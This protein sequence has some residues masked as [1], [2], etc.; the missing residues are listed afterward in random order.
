M[1]NT[2]FLSPTLR[3]LYCCAAAVFLFSPFSVYA[4]TTSYAGQCTSSVINKTVEFGTQYFDVL[5][6]AVKSTTGE[7]VKPFTS[8]KDIQPKSLYGKC[9]CG[10]LKVGAAPSY[11]FETLTPTQ[12][13]CT[14]FSD[15][16]KKIASASDPFAKGCVWKI[17][18]G[19]KPSDTGDITKKIQWQPVAPSLAINIPG[20]KGFSSPTP[21][22]EDSGK[23]IYISF[24]GEYFGALYRFLIFMAGIISAVLIMT[25]G[26]Q[27]I[28]AGGNSSQRSNALERIEGALVGLV[29]AIG[30]YLV[31]YIIN[32]DLVH[33]K[34][35]RIPVI[36][37]VQLED[38]EFPDRGEP[39]GTP[40]ALSDTTYDSLFQK[41]AGCIGM[42]WRVYKVLAYHESRLNPAAKNTKGSATGLFQVLKG[43][44]EKVLKK[45]GW[46]GYCQNPG[47]TNPAVSTAIVTQG[48]FKMALNSINGMCASASVDDKL[49]MLLF[50]NGSGPGALRKAIKNY[51]CD[52][53]AW[54][55]HPE[56]FH[57]ASY[58]N[59]VKTVKTMRGMGVENLTGA[60]NTSQCPFNTGAKPTDFPS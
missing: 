23:V 41:F 30:S 2:N 17:P 8:C 16:F 54:E 6:I 52:T 49:H 13:D 20:F 35:L 19:Y 11:A 27:W 47:L 42:D 32:P 1:L 10:L 50:N 22:Q 46:D 26:F 58:A 12:T 60:K 55:A 53:K 38:A 5:K 15:T 45:V 36:E 59:G 31:L 37:N 29:L 9:L 51:G 28:L 56:I 21:R 48:H 43:Y 18:E 14:I 24:L 7:L 4:E 39:T 3:V 25:G 33:F 40:K 57:A 44:C 34:S